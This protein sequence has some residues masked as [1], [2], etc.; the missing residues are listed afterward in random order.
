MG[1]RYGGGGIR[2]GTR[3][4]ETGLGVNG[5]VVGVNEVVQHSRM[6]FVV[7]VD[8]LEEVDRSALHLE[9]LRPF[10]QRAENRQAI[11]QRRLIVW[12]PRLCGRHLIAVSLVT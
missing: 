7:S 3:N 2:V 1:V 10:P 9:S 8:R 5:I 11:E 4:R 6:L 12:I